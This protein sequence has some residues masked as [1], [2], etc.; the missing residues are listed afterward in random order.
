MPKAAHIREV[1][2]ACE[3]LNLSEDQRAHL[4]LVFR[5]LGLEN[6]DHF[7]ETYLAIME[8][9]ARIEVDISGGT[10]RVVDGSQA[11]D[12]I[13]KATEL[14]LDYVDRTVAKMDAILLSSQFNAMLADAQRAQIGV[15]RSAMGRRIRLDAALVRWPG[16]AHDPV[17]TVLDALREHGRAMDPALTA[18]VESIARARSAELDL[19]ARKLFETSVESSGREILAFATH[20]RSS[21]EAFEERMS[22]WVDRGTTEREWVN[23]SNKVLDEML[24]LLGDD[25]MAATVRRAWLM[26]RAPA[27]CEGEDGIR[28]RLES[29]E[30]AL[31]TEDPV[32]REVRSIAADA[33]AAFEQMTAR[34]HE[35]RAYL[36]RNF[37]RMAVDRQEWTESMWTKRKQRIRAITSRLQRLVELP[38]HAPELADA[39][40]WALNL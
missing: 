31:A 34:E 10:T 3:L 12:A 40:D 6:R 13:S 32:T 29:L 24:E 7:R 30:A 2:Q 8:Q 37:R 22:A 21:P 18:L 38:N 36:S 19:R 1:A 39:L 23:A 14:V 26:A 15:V 28:G 17:L 33:E 35:W 16:A 20:D 27:S 9:S 25:P 5:S 4:D 11:E